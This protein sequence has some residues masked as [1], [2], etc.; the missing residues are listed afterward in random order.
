MVVLEMFDNVGV[1]HD[2][3]ELRLK[4]TKFA[5]IRLVKIVILYAA[6]YNKFDNDYAVTL[7]TN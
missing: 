6:D 7:K 5:R 3:W 1:G 2:S 4:G